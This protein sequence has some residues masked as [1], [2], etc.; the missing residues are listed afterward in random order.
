MTHHI[1]Q[2]SHHEKLV[3]KSDLDTSAEAHFML[4]IGKNHEQYHAAIKCSR[5]ESTDAYIS[6]KRMIKDYLKKRK[7]LPVLIIIDL[8]LNEQSL[9]EFTRFLN[10]NKW[11][12]YIPV[13]YNEQALS[14]YQ[15]SEITR[16]QLVDDIV[17]I[18][19]YGNE[20]LQK[21]FF[22]TKSKTF[23]GEKAC[24]QS[25]TKKDFTKFNHEQV[26]FLIRRLVEIII[27]GSLL[28]ILSPLLFFIMILIKTES[29]GPIIY[30]SRRAGKGCRIFDFYKFR[31]MTV[32]AE[33]SVTELKDLN[34]YPNNSNSPLFFK[35]LNDPRITRVGIFLR[36]TSLDE[37][38]QLINVIKG[39]MSLVGNRPLPLYEASTLTS[40]QWAERFLAP[41][42]ITGLWQVLKNS[43]K[44]ISTKE[45]LLLD[46]NYARNNSFIRDCWIVANTPRALFQK[47][48]M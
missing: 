17:N 36:N 42:G 35:A 37:L 10:C 41:A 20:L 1:N 28:I 46:I 39:D 7:K 3:R 27:A 31:T 6:A 48:K 30:R 11:T 44:N 8:M 24:Y 4:Y 15:I 19:T 18:L 45:R 43:K 33:A 38:P 34:I 16:L 25:I 9:N 22:L 40:D 26:I 32:N 14:H 5:Q 21:A 13:I 29:R 2:P 12:K 47:D 23:L